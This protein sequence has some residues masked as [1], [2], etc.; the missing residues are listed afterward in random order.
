MAVQD[1]TIKT[2]DQLKYIHDLIT[3]TQLLDKIHT[4]FDKNNYDYALTKIPVIKQLLDANQ[5]TQY[6]IGKLENY[7]ITKEN[8]IKVY[9]TETG[10]TVD[11][12]YSKNFDPTNESDIE[13][14]EITVNS[15]PKFV[16]KDINQYPDIKTVKIF[17]DD[18]NKTKR[19]NTDYAI[20]L[21]LHTLN[22]DH[23]K[24]GSGVYQML[25][26]TTDNVE[27]VYVDI[28]NPTKMSFMT[29]LT[30]QIEELPDFDIIQDTLP[31]K[32]KD[33]LAYNMNLLT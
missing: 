23:F 8:A 9:E 25:N 29:E 21:Q 31:S 13:N 17:L 4:I 12:S 2:T 3:D 27:N 1:G 11:T 16:S 7:G 33:T 19:V 28:Q 5:S 6:I 26:H 30:N 15:E 18:A 24:N 20:D 32:Y 10:E 22:S 14:M